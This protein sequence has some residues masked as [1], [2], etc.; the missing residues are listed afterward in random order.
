MKRAERIAKD[1]TKEK[2]ATNTDYSR[3]ELEKIEQTR[4]NLKNASSKPAFDRVVQRLADDLGISWMEALKVAND[5][6][7]SA[8]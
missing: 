6:D 4:K 7:S 1:K 8:R 3:K 2:V 5:P